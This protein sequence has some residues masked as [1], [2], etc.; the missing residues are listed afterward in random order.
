MYRKARSIVLSLRENARLEGL[1][2]AVRG[3]WEMSRERSCQ[4]QENSYS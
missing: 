4:E 3:V 2:R 1:K